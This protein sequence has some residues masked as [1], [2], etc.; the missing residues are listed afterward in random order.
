MEKNS[1]SQ[2]NTKPHCQ[3]C[4][5]KELLEGNDRLHAGQCHGKK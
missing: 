3:G 2:H 1:D 5:A 4:R